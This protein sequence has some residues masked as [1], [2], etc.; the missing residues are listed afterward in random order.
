MSLPQ[1]CEHLGRVTL[2]FLIQ[3]LGILAPLGKFSSKIMTMD[4]TMA[5]LPT[6]TELHIQAQLSQEVSEKQDFPK[7][8]ST[9]SF[10][11][12][13]GLDLEGLFQPW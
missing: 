2:S 10:L 13:L 3:F 6:H 5:L 1:Q 8:V 12:K 7:N 11:T 9:H 4:M